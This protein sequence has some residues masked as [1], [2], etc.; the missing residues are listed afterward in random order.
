MKP[1]TKRQL[2]KWYLEGRSLPE[3]AEKASSTYRTHVTVQTIYHIIQGENR[4]LQKRDISDRRVLVLNEVAKIDNLEVE[5]WNG[6]FRSIVNSNDTTTEKT[7]A[8]DPDAMSPDARKLYE[9]DDTHS[10][11]NLDDGDD[12]ADDIPDYDESTFGG[13]ARI[14]RTNGKYNTTSGQRQSNNPYN[15]GTTSNYNSARSGRNGKSARGNKSG[16][17]YEFISPSYQSSPLYDA[18]VEAPKPPQF[19]FTRKIIKTCGDTKFLTVVQWC[20]DRRCKLLGLDAPSTSITATV[21]TDHM[22]QMAR[23]IALEKG[24]DADLVV[25]DVMMDAERILKAM[26]APVEN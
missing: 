1:S 22:R 5:A 6:Y 10:P 23:E 12:D 4:L 26:R 8:T 14:E 24:L 20:I 16:K 25:E 18:E 19:S 9:I 17:R 15:S 2:I 3:I 11:S 13:W 7:V 21:N